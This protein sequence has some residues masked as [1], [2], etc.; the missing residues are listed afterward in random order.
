MKDFYRQ[1][2]IFVILMG[3]VLTCLIIIAALLL[4]YFYNGN[5]KDKYGNRLND[6]KDVK[7]T[8]SE[9]ANILTEVKKDSTIKEADMNVFGKVVYFD[10]LF[11]SGTDLDIAKS[12]SLI[13]L[14]NFSN[15][16]LSLYEFQFLIKEDATDG[17]LT[18]GA[19]NNNSEIIVWNN[20]TNKDS[21][22]L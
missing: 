20:N 14:D 11:V 3:I 12:K 22:E 9:K 6:I 13:I 8:T 7:I 15:E 1:N 10:L 4:V 16:E 18:S 5:A 19:R 17:F 2:R 21:E